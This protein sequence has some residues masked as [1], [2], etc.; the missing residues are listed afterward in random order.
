[1]VSGVVKF[2]LLELDLLCYA[3]V[4]M[5]HLAEINMTNESAMGLIFIELCFAQFYGFLKVSLG[6][7]L[8]AVNWLCPLMRMMNSTKIGCLGSQTHKSR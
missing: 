1:M 2:K 5:V 6:S 7:T 3:A 8:V 4:L